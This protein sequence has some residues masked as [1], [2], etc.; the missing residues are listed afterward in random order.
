MEGKIKFG[1]MEALQ[2]N[3][4]GYLVISIAKLL[5]GFNKECHLY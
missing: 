1:K 5:E 3:K 2:M 4:T